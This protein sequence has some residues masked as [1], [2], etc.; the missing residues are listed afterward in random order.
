MKELKSKRT[1]II[2]VLSNEDYADMVKQDQDRRI[3]L[4]DKFTVTDVRIK[5]IIPASIPELKEV[6]RES[7][8]KVKNKKNEG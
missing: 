7:D 2:S 5:N 1:G 3:K 6:K 4:L 8:V